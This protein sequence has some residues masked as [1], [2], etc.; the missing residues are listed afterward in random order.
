MNSQQEGMQSD[1]DLIRE[2]PNLQ[3]DAILPAIAVNQQ[4]ANEEPEEDLEQIRYD[5]SDVIN[6]SQPHD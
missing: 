1:N 3:Q 5:T 4:A 2:S 6:R